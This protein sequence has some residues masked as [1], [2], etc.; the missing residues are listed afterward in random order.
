M[1]VF[2]IQRVGETV[3][4]IYRELFVI[5][6]VH[7]AYETPQKS[8][9]DQHLFIET[10]TKTTE[11]FKNNRVRYQ[12]FQ[13]TLTCF[14]ETTP[15][16]PPTAEPKI[17]LVVMPADM[18]IRFLVKS[19]SDFLSKTYV[20]ATGSKDTYRFSNQVN[21]TGGGLTLITNPV[22]NHSAAKDY[23]AGTIVKSGTNLFAALKT[24]LASA[25]IPLSNTLFWKQITGV[26]QVVNNA[27][28]QSNTTVKADAIC[29]AVI[30]IQRAGVT[31]NSYKVLGAGDKLFN[32]AP[33]FTIK[34][35]SRI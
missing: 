10:D 28:L 24:V 23:P 8:F 9:I 22:E 27:D 17:P 34:F 31:I 5:R 12:F 14:V 29:F 4:T 30:D 26:E 32:P 18:S 11:F 16:N 35:K 13:N 21:N 33:V 2:N 3:S 20:A 6:F 19:S 7:P 15:F 25:G 1:T